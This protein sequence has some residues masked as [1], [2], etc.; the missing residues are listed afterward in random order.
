MSCFKVE[1]TFDRY[2]C[3]DCGTSWG[4]GVTVYKDDVVIYEQEP[5]AHCYNS[6]CVDLEYVFEQIL[7]DLGHTVKFVQEEE[8]L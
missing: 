1:Y 8:M 6:T 5:V 3:D 2:E 7:K 4:D